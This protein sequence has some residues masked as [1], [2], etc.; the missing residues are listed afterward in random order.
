M[1]KSILL[2]CLLIASVTVAFSQQEKPKKEFI[3]ALSENIIEVKPGET[4][5]V[6]V[7]LIRSNS[8]AKSK[9][10]LGISS[11][12]PAGITVTYEPSEGVIES[13]TAK[14]SISADTKPGTYTLLPNCV[15]SNRSKGTMLKVV[16]GGASVLP[17]SGK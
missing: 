9:A 1:K 3:L 15:I 2:A 11:A 12:L 13:S 6:K 7:N 4:K 10:K 16:V 5:E 14:I 17:A 8:F